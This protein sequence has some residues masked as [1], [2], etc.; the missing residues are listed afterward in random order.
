[1][2]YTL[3][4]TDEQKDFITNGIIEGTIKLMKSTVRSETHKERA[5]R[6]TKPHYQ[7]KN[8][9]TKDTIQYNILNEIQ[10]LPAR[11]RDF[12]KKLEKEERNIDKHELSDIL[13]TPILKNLVSRKKDKF[14]FPRGRP[15]SDLAEERRGAYSYYE[16]TE[17]LQIME[18]ILRDAERLKKIDGIVTNDKIYQEFLK[19]SSEVKKGEK[20]KNEIA[21]KNS[22]KPIKQRDENRNTQLIQ[23]DNNTLDRQELNI[24]YELGTMMF[25]NSLL[26]SQL[27]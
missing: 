27:D 4:L 9:I 3:D 13:S 23:K 5:N 2:F 15:N 6:F 22:Y 24:L 20:E 18:I 16:K 19:Y 25:F 17:F 21:F 10:K 14:P 26:L 11:P 1:M 8:A 7:S 12:R